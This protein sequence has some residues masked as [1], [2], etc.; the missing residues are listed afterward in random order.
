[1]KPLALL[2]LVG[3]LCWTLVSTARSPYQQALQHSRIR[4]RQHGPN[5]C[6]M[7]QAL[8]SSKK[9]YPS[10]KQWYQRKICGRPTLLTYECCPEYEKVPGEKGCPAALPLTNIYN[11]LGIIG[12]TTTKLYSDRAV[13]TPQIEG[14]GSFTMFAP[15]NEAWAALP[16]EILDALVSNVNIELLNALHYHMVDRRLHSSELKHGIT[17]PSLYQDLNLIIHHYPNGIIT[18][19]CARLLKTDNRAT[20]GVVH[21]ID[22]V[23]TA[24]T[25]TI[26]ELIETEDGLETLLA[27]VTASDLSTMLNSEGQYTLFAPTDEA[28]KK[29][30]KATLNRIMGDPVSLKALLNHHILK[31][32]QCSEAILTGYPMDTLEGTP[33][34]VGCN[35]QGTITINGK[36]IISQKDVMATNGVIHF[37]DELLIP[38]S[39]K[40]I[41]E[42]AQDTKVS[43]FVD[44]LVEAGLDFHLKG[45]ETLTLLAPHDEV[46][47]DNSMVVTEEFKTLLQ[48]HIIKEQIS[49]KDI[50]DG[51]I[52]V[53][54]GGK[55][56]RAFVYRNS[57]CIENSCIVAHDKKGRFGSLFMMDKVLTPPFGTVMDVLKADDRFSLLV[58]SIQAAGLTETLNRPGTFT[59]FAPTDEAFQAL[60]S[61]EMEKLMGNRR[62][63]ESLLKYHIANEIRVSGGVSE[64]ARLLTLQGERLDISTKNDSIYIN[65]IP[66]LEAD[67]MA[68]NGVVHAIN[69]VLQP[70]AFR[71][72]ERGDEPAA[73]W[74]EIYKQAAGGTQDQ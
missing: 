31:T 28:F 17:V 44:M 74:Y 3:V 2:A 26:H 41:M 32:V 40:T 5:V 59:V 70:A 72:A 36:S 24:V 42:L 10:C 58:A 21:I 48:D 63:L 23:I 65:K 9:Y 45:S 71:I 25:N 29:I 7:Q 38:D 19:N 47:K 68:T 55:K 35:G 53:T 37:I 60:P 16:T 11:T 6:A 1:M 8:G 14:P 69:R 66:V 62:Q 30:P 46:F 52:L 54:L 13:L 73:S 57:L 15:S 67:I 34:E 64:L 39:A 22:K 4:G 43:T 12:G 50:Y 61:G 33:L 27:A 56:L 20:N 49:T 18:V 51:Q